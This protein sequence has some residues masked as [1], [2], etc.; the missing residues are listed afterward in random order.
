MRIGSEP[1]PNVSTAALRAPSF[2]SGVKRSWRVTRGSG[3]VSVTTHSR[4]LP[5]PRSTGISSTSGT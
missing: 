2:E 3:V 4:Y 1:G 5:K